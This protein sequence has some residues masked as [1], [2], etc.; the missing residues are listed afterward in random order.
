ML[1]Y[2]IEKENTYLV[3]GLINFS[4]SGKMMIEVT[5]SIFK[6]FCLTTLMPETSNIQ[7]RYYYSLYLTYYLPT[8]TINDE[9]IN[10][11]PDKKNHPNAEVENNNKHQTDHE[12]TLL[13]DEILKSLGKKDD[14]EVQDDEEQPKKRKRSVKQLRKKK[15]RKRKKLITKHRYSQFIYYNM[16]F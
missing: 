7:N 5:A 12:E 2:N 6:N 4:D 13:S 3:S 1:G 11:T 14:F 16:M 9:K 8:F 15:A 10:A